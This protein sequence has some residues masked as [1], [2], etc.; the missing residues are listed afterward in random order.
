DLAAMVEVHEDLPDSALGQHLESPVD[1]G[2][3]ADG[4]HR[5]RDIGRERIQARPLTRRQNDRLHV[6]TFSL[7]YAIDRSMPS[8]SPTRGRHPR[9]NSRWMPA[10][11]ASAS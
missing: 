4:Q 7:T 5:L 2:T 10:S 8:R 9:L 3:T 1:H 6:R 11:V